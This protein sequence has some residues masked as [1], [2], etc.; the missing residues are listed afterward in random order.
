MLA[1]YGR[2]YNCNYFV[3]ELLL[4]N[5]QSHDERGLSVVDGTPVLMKFRLLYE[6]EKYLQVAYLEYR[7]RQQ[8]YFQLQSVEVNVGSNVKVDIYSQYVRTVRLAHD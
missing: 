6:L 1:I 8:A 5:S 2:I 7:D 3:E 4:F